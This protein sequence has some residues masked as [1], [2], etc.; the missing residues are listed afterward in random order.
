[1]WSTACSE[2][3]SRTKK[4]LNDR[5]LIIKHSK[6]NSSCHWLTCTQSVRLQVIL[7]SD[8]M[9]SKSKSKRVISQI[10]TKCISSAL[11]LRLITLS[12][13]LLTWKL[14]VCLVVVTVSPISLASP[15]SLKVSSLLLHLKAR[16]PLC[17]C[18]WDFILIQVLELT[19]TVTFYNLLGGT[20]PC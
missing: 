10:S 9:N 2:D 19:L 5:F 13:H 6:R 15:R 3:S 7:C 8:S 1:M 16:T 20:I 12:I 18:R 17:T 4:E 11:V 14:S